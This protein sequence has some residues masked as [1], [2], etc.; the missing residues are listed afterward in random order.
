MFTFRVADSAPIR[1]DVK[2]TL[3]LQEDLAANVL[4]HPLSEKS[5]L[6]A[7]ANVMLEMLNATA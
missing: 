3:M 5:P 2:V 4:P 7:P 6:V 1:L